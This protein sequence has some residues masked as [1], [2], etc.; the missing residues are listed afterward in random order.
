MSSR[1]SNS[2][3]VQDDDLKLAILKITK[4]LY[5][6]ICKCQKQHLKTELNEVTKSQEMKTEL[7]K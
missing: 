2:G 3:D 5:E 4:E 1:K 7:N 6:D